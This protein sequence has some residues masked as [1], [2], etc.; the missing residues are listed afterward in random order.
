MA[1]AP[2]KVTLQEAAAR[3]GVHYMTV[4]RYVRL[5]LLAADKV[6]GTW[7]IALRDLEDLRQRSAAGGDVQRRPA[8]WADRLEARLV[9]GDSRGAW[10]VI[11]AAL[12]AGTDL[13]DVYLEVIAPA[14][15]AIGRRWEVA[16]VDIAIEHR[17]SVIAMRIVGRLGHRFARRGRTRGTVVVGNPTGER[18]ALPVALLADVVRRAGWEVWEL[19]ADVPTSSFVRAAAEVEHLV[20][21]GVSISTPQCIEAGADAIAALRPVVNGAAI[22]VGGHAVADGS[23]ASALGADGWAPDGK[24]AVAVLEALMSGRAPAMP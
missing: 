9:V 2:T 11:E 22:L 14:M 4:Y 3:L 7:R 23:D 5:G 17:A 19:G 1:E 18:H 15:S 21:V 13:E 20:A 8:P 16:E 10:G 6:G 12:T 24:Q